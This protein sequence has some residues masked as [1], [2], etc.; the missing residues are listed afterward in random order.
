MTPIRQAL[1]SLLT[2]PALIRI[3]VTAAAIIAIVVGLS[4]WIGERTS[5]HVDWLP[6]RPIDLLRPT[7]LYLAAIVPVFYLLRVVSL[8]DLSLAQQ[9]TQATLRSLVI[10]G[11][12][13]ALARPS[14]ITEQ[15]KVAT[16]VVVDVS[17]SVS[18]K[19]LAAA[20]DYVDTVAAA[21]GEGN[22]QVVTFAEKPRVV[23]KAEG[24]AL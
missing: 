2:V 10:L 7:A 17:D 3:A 22:L 4:L 16:L 5:L 21:A 12:A 24:K 23:R 19:Q 15:S 20:R 1:R 8:T 18:D 14:W 13:V 9:L 6:S 11:I